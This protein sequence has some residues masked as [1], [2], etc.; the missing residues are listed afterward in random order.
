MSAVP[1]PSTP[2]P[3]Q[4][5]RLRDLA[6]SIEGTPARVPAIKRPPV[7]CVCSGKGGVGKTT[8]AV[9]LSIALSAAGRQP[10]LID[11]DVGTANADLVFGVT[12]SRR[13]DRVRSQPTREGLESVAITAPGGVR[14]LPGVACDGWVHDFTPGECDRLLDA[15]AQIRPA[16]GVIVIDAGAGIGPGVMSFVMMAD[17]AV[18]VATPEPTSMADAYAL[19]KAVHLSGARLGRGP[20]VRMGVVVNEVRNRAE[21][22]QVFARLSE[23]ARRFLGRELIG[24]G[25]IPIDPSVGSAVRSRCPLLLSQ[26]RSPGA[27][28]IRRLCKAVEAAVETSDNREKPRSSAALF[29]RNL[30]FRSSGTPH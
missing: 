10:L 20:E 4:A 8:I 1:R 5:A 18:V 14:L 21:A 15:C 22:G 9:N 2:P 17:L 12:A 13:L 6:R 30:L 16:P 19:V 27:E 11:A 26:A 24:L 7:V 3:D 28:G 29:V 23:C 25:S